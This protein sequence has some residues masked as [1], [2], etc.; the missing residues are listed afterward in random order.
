MFSDVF[1]NFSKTAQDS[2]FG[3]EILH[4]M[5]KSK[6]FFALDVGTNATDIWQRVDFFTECLNLI[7]D[8]VEKRNLQQMMHFCAGIVGTQEA[9]ENRYENVETLENT[10]NDFKNS[11]NDFSKNLVAIGPC[12]INHDWESIEFDVGQHDF[13]DNR[14]ISDEKD[15]FA[16]QM[17]LAKKINLPVVVYSKK[18]FKETSDVLKAIKWNRGVIHSY[19]YSKSEL[20]FFL[21]LGWYISFDGNVTYSGKKNAL[22]MAETVAYVPKDRILIESNSPFYAPIPL[23]NTLNTP[24]NINYIYDYVAS[25]RGITSSKLG[26]QIE[27]NCKKLF[28]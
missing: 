25:K 11:D 10:I 23:K 6:P 4:E 7:D 16:L 18:G 1:F 12:G 15:L 13:F 20:D 28:L 19:S 3:L 24:N 2:D 22:D 17:T 27:E 21:D 26:Q 14:T 5:A 8:V 9:I